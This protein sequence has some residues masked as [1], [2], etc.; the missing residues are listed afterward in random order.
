MT[1]ASANILS[2]LVVRTLRDGE[3]LTRLFCRVAVGL[4]H[5]RTQCSMICDSSLLRKHS[6]SAEVSRRLVYAF[7][8]DGPPARRRG[9]RTTPAQLLLTLQPS[10]QGTQL[11][12]LAISRFTGSVNVLWMR[13]PGP[14]TV[15]DASSRC[16]VLRV[17]KLSA[18]DSLLVWSP[19]EGFRAVLGEC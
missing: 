12:T 7:R 3:E 6:R 4:G 19:Q 1:L 8:R 10:D 14:R 17:Y 13:N 2:V 16:F 5:L 11:F 18:R 9:R 15:A